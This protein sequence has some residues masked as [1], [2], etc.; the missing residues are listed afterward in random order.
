MKVI[1]RRKRMIKILPKM[2]KMPKTI[3]I[4]NIKQ[5]MKKKRRIIANLIK[6]NKHRPHR[7]NNKPQLSCHL[8]LKKNKMGSQSPVLYGLCLL[9]PTTSKFSSL[10]II[11]DSPK[12][13]ISP[14][15]LSI[16]KIIVVISQ[17]KGTKRL[18]MFLRP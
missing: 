8:L 9:D 2:L 18:I 12:R 13:V 1:L 5:I 10:R 3:R 14:E 7:K 17:K 11:K 6:R 4:K 15:I 16:N